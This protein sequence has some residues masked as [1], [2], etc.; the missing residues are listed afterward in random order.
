MVLGGAKEQQSFESRSRV[1]ELKH[2]SETLG[3]IERLFRKAEV[4]ALLR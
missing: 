4:V 3:R 1:S 2:D